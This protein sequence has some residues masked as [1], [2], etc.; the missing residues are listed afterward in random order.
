M[1]FQKWN[2]EKVTFEQ[3]PEEGEEKCIPGDQS[4]KGK[5]PAAAVCLV[6]WKDPS[7]CQC[8]WNKVSQQ[9][10]LEGEVREK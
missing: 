2:D 4:S 8:G 3:S 10:V 9:K 6:C 1:E 7:G 5:V